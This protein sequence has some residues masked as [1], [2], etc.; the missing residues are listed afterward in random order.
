MVFYNIILVHMPVW[1]QLTSNYGN[2]YGYFL[3]L[4]TAYV[5]VDHYVYNEVISLVTSKF[6]GILTY[7]IN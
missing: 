4:F 1:S 6:P 2:Y 3:E 7:V 5:V